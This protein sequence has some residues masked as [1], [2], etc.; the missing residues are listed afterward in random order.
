MA[1]R[2]RRLSS[3][4]HETLGD[5]VRK[6]RF[7]AKAPG[8]MS[9]R[10]RLAAIEEAADTAVQIIEEM[11]TIRDSGNSSLP[12][13][14]CIRGKPKSRNKKGAKKP[15]G[16][17]GHPGKT[18]ELVLDPEEVIPLS[19]PE[20][21][22][23]PDWKPAGEEIRQVVDIEIKR[24]VTEYRS[25]IFLNP[26]TDEERRGQFPE[27]VNAAYQYGPS[28]KGLT[29]YL[30]DYQHESYGRIVE[31]FRDTAGIPVNESSLV[32]MVRVG[33]ASEVLVEYEKVAKEAVGESECVGA[34]ET[35]IKVKK[36]KHWVQ[37][38]STPLFTLLLLYAKRGKEA[39][40]GSG[41]LD[42]F[43]GVLVHDCLPVYF[44][45]LYCLHAVCNAHILRELEAAKE[46]NQGWAYRMHDFLLDL[47]DLVD[48]YGGVLPLALQLQVRKMYR[49][50]IY[51]GLIAT[52]GI[53][54]AR[55]PGQKGKR[56]RIAK[57]KY[58]NLLER[59]WRYEDA[60]LRFMTDKAVPFT[61]N[62]TEQAQRVLKLH[63][64]ISGCFKSLEMAASYC[65]MRGYIDT[66]R[67]HGIN[68]YKAIQMALSGQRPY[69]IAERL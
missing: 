38:F 2:S 47:H 10:N 53:V 68:A 29:V 11:E 69:F 20:C 37:A 30:R 6:I 13:S 15:G 49:E 59:L 24:H 28:V 52:G 5:A 7:L 14:Q 22:G 23:N 8:R 34:D 18:Y 45:L 19:P 61:N 1:Q 33:E 12:P 65:R 32:D 64:K 3:A 42:G 4:R 9:L 17:P 40:V 50:I 63:M 39:I 55:P 58:R 36:E 31:F 27:G 35:P 56:G 21:V 43:T 41:V 66:C 51:D 44:T 60:V 46:M 67:K 54:L 62:E 57:P 25:Q 26:D 16:Q 48:C